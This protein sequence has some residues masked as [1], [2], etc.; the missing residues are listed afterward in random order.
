M[1]YNLLLAAFVFSLVSIAALVAAGITKNRM[2]LIGARVSVALAMGLLTA[3]VFF[4]EFLL[5]THDFSY[6]YVAMYTSEDLS[7]VYL[8]GALWAGNVGTM[9]FWTWL[10]SIIAVLVL[11]TIRGRSRELMPYAAV[12]VMITETFLLSL[13]IFVQNPF[14]QMALVPSEGLGLNPLL[15]NF[16]M[17]VHPP[18]I[19][20]GYAALAVPFALAIAA[21][22]TGKLDNDWVAT[23]RR[24]TLF[25]W[26]LLTAGIISGGW[27]SYI[28]LAEG[29]Y[30]HWEPVENVT[31]IPWL[32]ATALLHSLSMQKKRGI[33]K[34]WTLLLITLTFA[35]VI[36]A[37]LVGRSEIIASIHSFTESAFGPAFL[38][39]LMAALVIPCGL[40][41]WRYK[42]LKSERQIENAVSREG[43]FLLTNLL[44][45]GTA[46]VLLAGTVFLLVNTDARNLQNNL[47]LPFY[48]RVSAPLFL[49]I[50]LLTGVCTVVGWKH[51]NLRSLGRDLLPPLAAGVVLA[52]VVYLFG[53]NN[54]YA[55]IGMG[56][57]LVVPYAVVMEWIRSTRARHRSRGENYLKAFFS[58]IGADKPRHGGYIV[59]IALV[60]IAAGVIGT[61][62]YDSTAEK[63]L[64]PGDSMTVGP[65]TLTYEQLNYTPAQGR[66]IFLADISVSR[67][68]KLLGTLV[69]RAYFDR[70]FNG[71]INTSAIRS[72]LVDDLYVTITGWDETSLTE[73]K[74]SIYPLASWLW[75]G[76]VLMTLGGMVAFWPN[77]KNE[78]LS[79]EDEE[80]GS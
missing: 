23:T 25:A 1:G 15:E 63:R 69:P 8:I 55:A 32:S 79:A 3:A 68:G 58:L 4:M 33:F 16:I 24:W 34:M 49:V 75:I 71:D 22:V 54:W 76:G 52:V 13:L 80:P 42:R 28:R 50:L 18:V 5:L 38:Y 31:L 67:N 17:L 20:T 36:F 73:F 14:A 45:L 74:A 19:M 60:M 11:V 12:V 35:I 26:L 9:L 57:C 21:L 39:F 62:A 59:H 7:P 48:T 65:Y 43:T 47:A 29:L 72:T 44:L 56:A 53:L 66:M 46:L 78:G 61:T 30:W 51:D 2:V 41:A 77:S 27:F 10:F 6:E 40:I 37:T 64:L 70:S